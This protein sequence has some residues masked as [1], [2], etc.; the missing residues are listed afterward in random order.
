MPHTMSIS[1]EIAGRS[2]TYCFLWQMHQ[3]RGPE[4]REL[5]PWTVKKDHDEKNFDLAEVKRPSNIDRG[6]P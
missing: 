4:V 3:A 2:L 5:G 1:A 6:D